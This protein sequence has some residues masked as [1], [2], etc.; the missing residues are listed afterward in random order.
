MW[1]TLSYME[2][3]A[4]M[5]RSVR[6]NIYILV[7]YCVLVRDT[8]RSNP[9][10]EEML[11]YCGISQSSPIYTLP[12]EKH[13]TRQTNIVI[14]LSTARFKFKLNPL[15]DTVRLYDRT[16]PV[17]GKVNVVRCPPPPPLLSWPVA[18]TSSLTARR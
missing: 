17:L 8:Y 15:G 5:G 7:S 2:I 10:F 3:R 6:R 16:G 12:S 18:A 9:P 13:A 4:R 11:W 1:F 14:V